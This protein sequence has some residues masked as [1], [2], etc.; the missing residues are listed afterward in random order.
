M[1]AGKVV[2]VTGAG[3]GIGRQFA[4]GFAASGARVVVN[5]LARTGDSQAY[6]AD[7][8]VSEIKEEGGE[9]VSGIESV[10]ELA[11]AQRIVP[12]AL[13]HF[14]RIYSRLHKPRVTRA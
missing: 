12:T 5:D 2:V 3:S 13:D 7:G 9:A 8:V 10:A 1:V 6:A 11:S 14:C 4:K